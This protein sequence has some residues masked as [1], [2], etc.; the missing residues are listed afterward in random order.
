MERVKSKEFLGVLLDEKL[1]WKDHIKYIENKVVKNI[2]LLYRV[3][4][5]L[6][7]TRYLHYTFRMFTLLTLYFSHIHTYLNYA[8]L[9]WCSTNRTNLK[10]LLSQQEHALRIINVRTRFDHTNDFFNSQKY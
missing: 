2:R 5:I 1:S 4:L 6:D 9:P 3:K 7:Q 10:W 8:N